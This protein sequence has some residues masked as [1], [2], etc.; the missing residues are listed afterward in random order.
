MRRAASVVV[1]VAL[2]AKSLDRAAR[3]VFLTCDVHAVVHC[4]FRVEL[5]L[6]FG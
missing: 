2:P 1:D 5:R 4:V 6:P 3:T